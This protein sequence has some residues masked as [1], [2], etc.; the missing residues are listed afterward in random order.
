[1]R[2][3]IPF[4]LLLPVLVSAQGLRFEDGDWKTVLDKARKENRLVYVDVYATW[5][6]PCKVLAATIFPQKE[7]GDVY[8]AQFVNYRIDAEKGEGIELAE[9]YA[10]TAFPTHLF[11]DPQTEAVV[12]RTTG[13]PRQA[14]GFNAFAQTA[15]VEKSDPM[16]WEIYTQSFRSG[17]RDPQF[18]KDYLVKAARL[19]QPNEPIL[20][21]YIATLDTR[22]LPDSTLYFVASHANTIWS[23][24]LPLLEQNRKRLEKADT[25]ARFYGFQ[26][27]M[28][29][30][31]YPSYKRVL[32]AKDEG[33]LQTLVAFIRTHDSEDPDE[34]IFFYRKGFYEKT[35]NATQL[36]SVVQAEARRIL[37][38]KLS[39]YREGDAKARKKME[40]Q[41]RYQLTGMTLS[42]TDNVDSIVA[43]NVGRNVGTHPSVRAASTL[44]DFAWDVYENSKATAADLAQALQWSAK[45]LE[46]TAPHPVQWAGNA[47]THASLLY[48]SGKKADAI[49][50]EEKAIAALK[51]AGEEKEVASY[52][53]TLQKMKAGTY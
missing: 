3:L 47:D 6:G 15:L 52:A 28:D 16:T 27:K 8:N 49:A 2:F 25:N 23:N 34:S 1:M 12:Y 33:K 19:D 9:K 18:L 11:I 20:D 32:D 5:C 30:I 45:A 40:A 44:N 10:V 26:H 29:R 42:D 7:A 4:F 21:A 17:K 51:K 13:A 24:A 38:K 48:R 36:K 50:L 14:A 39:D 35:E 46:L 31:T 53:E 22:N 41:V 37:Q 43:Y